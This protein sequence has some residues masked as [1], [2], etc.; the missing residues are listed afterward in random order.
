MEEHVGQIWHRIITRAAATG[1]P[2]A[3]VELKEVSKTVGVLFRALG[4][5]GGLRIEATTAAA[6]GARRNWLQRIAG[7]HKQ[8]E[9]CW[10]DGE[11]LRLPAQINLFP[12]RAI[13]RDLYLWLAALA[14]GKVDDTLP[15]FQLNQQLTK[16]TLLNFPGLQPRYQ[17]LVESLLTLRP[18]LT[19][20]PQDEAAAERAIQQALR[21][22]G[23]VGELPQAKRPHQ[24]VLLWLHPSPPINTSNLVHD[25]EP[26]TQQPSKKNQTVEDKRRRRG[27]RT[28]MPDGKK[29]LLAFRL[30][31]LFTLAEYVKVDRCTDEE[32]ESDAAKNA[33][34]DM[35]TVSVARDNK[36]AA[37]SLR[38]DLDLPAPDYDDTPLGEG[39]LLPEWDY[40]RQQLRP[41]YCC[42]Q[43]MQATSAIPVELPSHLKRVAHRLRRQFEALTPKRIW[44]KG[45][46]DGS[47][48]DLDAYLLHVA[49][50]G[51]VNAER[52]LYRDFRGGSRDLACLLL[53]DLSLSTDAWFN[54]KARVIEVI[55]DS[56][57]L[58]AESLSA[59]GDQFAIYGFSSRHR[60][61]VRF[62]TIKTFKQSYNAAVRGRILMIKPGYYTRMGAAIRH[63][64]TLLSQ[65]KVS[66]PLLLLLTDGK[67]N[68]LDQYE[69][70]YGV[71]DTRMALHEARKLGLQP[72]CVT[73]DEKASDYLP[74]IFGTNNYVVIRNPSELPR[75]LPRLYARLTH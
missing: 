26:I 10:R 15:W 69:G 46:Q 39:I 33:L 67:P 36:P 45:Q 38:F 43:T 64:S 40:K 48:I 22:P 73:I 56:L 53:A 20:L 17:R 63:A 65:Q 44:H 21:H 66:Q 1:Y 16:K 72:F 11:V 31:S 61:H 13:N 4:G 37:T 9:L 49:E 35:D 34:D 51:R 32:E 29:G 28:E 2:Q 58:F 59:T 74:H 52:G 19:R 71:E 60:S 41:D 47:E 23:T 14:A 6:H 12:E 70:R 27:E 50:R 42:L 75:E 54:N 24:P 7:T 55:R 3:T 8:V 30:E 62:N 5:D 25:D 68:D 18:D 57:F